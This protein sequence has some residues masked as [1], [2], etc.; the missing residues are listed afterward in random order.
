MPGVESAMNSVVMETIQYR[1]GEGLPLIQISYWPSDLYHSFRTQCKKCTHRPIS[2]EP[3]LPEN[4]TYSQYLDYQR[5]IKPTPLFN[6]FE[7]NCV[8]VS[9]DFLLSNNYYIPKIAP[10]ELRDRNLSRYYIG[11]CPDCA[12]VYW[13]VAVE[14]EASPDHKVIKD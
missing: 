1:F 7:M 9:N 13:S 11:Q 14:V 12:T 5:C 6:L 8:D 2:F 4:A 3:A 10:K